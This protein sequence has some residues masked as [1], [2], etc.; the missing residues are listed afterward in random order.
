MD[1]RSTLPASKVRAVSMK[2]SMNRWA[3][4]V[5]LC[6]FLQAPATD[7]FFDW[8]VVMVAP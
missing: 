8:S 7:T 5:D 2:H 3:R 6:S 1:S 4:D